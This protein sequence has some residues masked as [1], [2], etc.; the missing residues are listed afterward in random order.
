MTR[1][2][3]YLLDTDIVIYWLKNKY[4]KINKKIKKIDDE[5][6]FISSISVAELYFGAFNSAKKEE[7]KRL[8][9]SKR[10]QSKI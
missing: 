4:P 5:R 2:K 6:I 9:E 8:M 10:G 7:N 3:T 1:G